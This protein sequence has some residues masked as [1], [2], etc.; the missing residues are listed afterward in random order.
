VRNIFI[1][2]G[3]AQGVSLS[4]SQPFRELSPRRRLC[5][6]DCIVL[7]ILLHSPKQGISTFTGS[8][9][10]IRPAVTLMSTEFQRPHKTAS[11]D[12]TTR[13]PDSGIYPHGTYD[14]VRT[15]QTRI[16]GWWIRA[17][18]HRLGSGASRYNW[19]PYAHAPC[20]VRRHRSRSLRISCSLTPLTQSYFALCRP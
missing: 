17:L 16:V 3:S 20:A 12:L 5:C 8:D 11:H 4:S 1:N 10:T 13:S 2:S 6:S 7:R 19:M 18:D 9:A 14:A 15:L